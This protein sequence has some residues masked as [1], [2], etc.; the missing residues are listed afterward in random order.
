MKRKETDKKPGLQCDKGLLS[1]ETGNEMPDNGHVT[2][3]LSP[4]FDTQI[5]VPLCKIAQVGVIPTLKMAFIHRK[6]FAPEKAGLGQSAEIRYGEYHTA[7]RDLPQA[8]QYFLR[9]VHVFE[10]VETS[11]NVEGLFAELREGI[12]RGCQLHRLAV[13]PA[14]GNA[15]R[16]EVGASGPHPPLGGKPQGFAAT[17]TI[18]EKREP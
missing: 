5:A 2:V 6:R 14:D 16:V 4:S 9:P 1:C 8:A 17:T 3:I 13:S 11:D 18:I 7:P 12:V 15:F 10:N